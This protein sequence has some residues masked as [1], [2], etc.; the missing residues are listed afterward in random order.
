MR[1]PFDLVAR[2]QELEQELSTM[3][4][5]N[6]QL[7]LE[8]DEMERERANTSNTAPLTLFSSPIRASRKLHSPVS[9]SSPTQTHVQNFRLQLQS[10]Q[11]ALIESQRAHAYT[12]EQK[13][14]YEQRCLAQTD[15]IQTLRQQLAEVTAS[16]LSLEQDRE[17]LRR[18]C[19][20]LASVQSQHEHL[21]RTH[22]QLEQGTPRCV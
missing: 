11:A 1:Q 9:P 3:Q 10:A 13:R 22:H 5:E 17:H 19:A 8:L 4:D 14:A 15:E 12:E 6:T 16:S 21:T 7:A 18:Q 20:A 2:V